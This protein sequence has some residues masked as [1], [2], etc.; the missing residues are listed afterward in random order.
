MLLRDKDVKDDMFEALKA[1]AGDEYGS[2][3]HSQPPHPQR[4]VTRVHVTDFQHPSAG[5]GEHSYKKL[6]ER[7]DT[8]FS[9]QA[10]GTQGRRRLAACAAIIALAYL[11][12]ANVLCVV[13]S[14]CACLILQM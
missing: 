11:I 10:G 9:L 5:E 8:Q 6:W 13:V 14:I 3:L 12:R 1:E 7:V 2:S 4:S